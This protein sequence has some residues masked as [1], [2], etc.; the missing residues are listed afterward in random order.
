MKATTKDHLESRKAEK[1]VNY[2]QQAKTEYLRK[3]KKKSGDADALEQV[4]DEQRNQK[5]YNKYQ[6]SEN[7][8]ENENVAMKRGVLC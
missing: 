5:R 1:V 6:K 8:N 4:R 3:Q 7:Q 2:R